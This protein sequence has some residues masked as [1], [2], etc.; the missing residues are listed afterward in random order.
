MPPNPNAIEIIEHPHVNL[1]RID[2][3][4]YSKRRVYIT[5]AVKGEPYELSHHQYI[6]HGPNTTVSPL[7]DGPEGEVIWDEYWKYHLDCLVKANGLAI[8]FERTYEEDIFVTLPG[9]ER[10]KIVKHT[11]T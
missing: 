5:F 1:F 9:R 2:S 6:C 3:A 7:G 11:R 4:E 8:R 10:T